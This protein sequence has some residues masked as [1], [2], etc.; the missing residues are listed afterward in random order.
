MLALA[1]TA[2]YSFLAAQS[3]PAA[4]AAVTSAFLGASVLPVYKRLPS[5]GAVQFF[6]DRA[7]V[8]FLAVQGGI[9]PVTVL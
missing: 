9:A 7:R 5:A 6:G 1:A 3:P 2:A 8:P 4:A